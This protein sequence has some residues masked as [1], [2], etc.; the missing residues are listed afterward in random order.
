MRNPIFNSLL[1]GAFVLLLSAPLNAQE[2]AVVSRNVLVVGSGKVLKATGK[3]ALVVSKES[4]EIG[5]QVTKFT[6]K[7]IVGP[8]L[9]VVVVKAAPAIAEATL[10]TTTVMARRGLPLAGKFA[11]KYLVR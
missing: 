2:T 10:K 6:A 7:E 3:I 11:L 9:K 5:W 1:F 8:T 4:A